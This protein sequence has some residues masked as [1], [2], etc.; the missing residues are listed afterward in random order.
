MGEVYK[1]RDTR[2]ERAVAIKVLPAHLASDLQFRDRFDRE[3]RAISALDHPHICALYDVGQ[4]DSTSF[5]VMQYLE[6]ETLQERLATGALPLGQAFKAAIEIA[7]ALDQAHRAWIVHRDLKPGNIMLTAAGVKLFDFGLA[8]AA[9]PI[10]VDAPTRLSDPE[11]TSPGIIVGTVQYMAPEQIEGKPIDARTDIFAF[12]AILFEMLCGRKAFAGGTQASVM[13]AILERDP[14]FPSSLASHVPS[15]LDRLVRRCL[16]K[17]PEDRWQTAA[18]LVRQLQQAKDSGAAPARPKRL[19]KIVDSLAVLP[20]VNA[21]HD[22]GTEYLS[23]GITESLINAFSQLPH[24][25]VIPRT[26]AFRYKDRQTDPIAV[27]RDL[28]V[29]AVLTGKVL[30]RGDTLSF[31]PSSWTSR[32]SP[33]CGVGNTTGSLPMSLRCSR[34]SRRR[35]S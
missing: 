22:P 19:S 1:A 27:G 24:L 34:K 8:K 7:S 18:D 10:D 9:T 33:R 6:G 3:A 35:S 14:P 15:A 5:L 23:E 20:F 32:N 4:Q 2:L 29:R 28:E 30:Q 11:L 16:A 13:A 26:S 25:R 12:G 21:S 31:R 17:R